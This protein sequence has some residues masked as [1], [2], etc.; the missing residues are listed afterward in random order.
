MQALSVVIPAFNERQ[1]IEKCIRLTYS[2]LDRL[3]D[4]FEIIVVDDASFDG[5]FEVACELKEKENLSRLKILKNKTNKGQGTSLK[6]GFHHAEKSILAHNSVDMPFNNDDWPKLLKNVKD[7]DMVIV[8]RINRDNYGLYR[9]II[10][11]SFVFL[12]NTLF[13]QKFSDY[14]F[15]Q[16]FKRETYLEC[17]QSQVKGTALFMPSLIICASKEKKKIIKMGA[18]FHSR[19]VGKA[20]GAS[21]KNIARGIYELLLLRVGVKR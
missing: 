19:E 16:A 20:T 5:T 8:E 7:A 13:S 21:L 11:H 9:K 2:K 10:S 12:I 1:G 6:I 15:I 14:S 3:L 4:D 18:Q 17:V